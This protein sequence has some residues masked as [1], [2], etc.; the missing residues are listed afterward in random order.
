[1]CCVLRMHVIFRC[2]LV[3]QP[4]GARALLVSHH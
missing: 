4:Y 3:L 1:V 2:A